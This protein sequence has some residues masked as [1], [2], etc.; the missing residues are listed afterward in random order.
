M[1]TTCNKSFVLMI[2]NQ[3]DS[4]T[5]SWDDMRDYCSETGKRGKVFVIQTNIPFGGSIDDVKTSTAIFAEID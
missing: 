2:N 1:F 4:V 5:R 3:I